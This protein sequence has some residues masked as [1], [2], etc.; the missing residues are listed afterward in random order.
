M[1]YVLHSTSLVHNAAT[2]VLSD[3]PE[4]LSVV[5]QLVLRIATLSK[6][7][8]SKSPRSFVIMCL[9]AYFEFTPSCVNAIAGR[10]P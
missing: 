7:Q 10:R 9:H 4:R 5:I 6:H 2:T 8:F 1:L 3:T